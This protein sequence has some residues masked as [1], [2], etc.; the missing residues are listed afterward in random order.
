[1]SCYQNLC[2][3]KIKAEADQDELNICIQKCL[4]CIGLC[5]GFV[6]D[7]SNLKANN[8][9]TIIPPSMRQEEKKPQ[10]D[11]NSFYNPDISTSKEIDPNSVLERLC[12]PDLRKI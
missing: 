3:L 9:E 7:L 10:L 12:F 2:E 6:N 11:S 4:S 5:Y 8:Q 1:M